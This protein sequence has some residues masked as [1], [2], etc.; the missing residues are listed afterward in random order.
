MEEIEDLSTTTGGDGARMDLLSGVGVGSVPFV[1]QQ[2][3]DIWPH[4]PV[5]LRAMVASDWLPPV[6]RGGG[7]AGGQPHQSQ[8][9]IRLTSAD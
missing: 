6:T 7:G 1:S 3:G 4:A 2:P 9:A 8:N 5:C